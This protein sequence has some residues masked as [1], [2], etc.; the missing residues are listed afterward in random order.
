[1]NQ[2]GMVRLLVVLPATLERASKF[3]VYAEPRVVRLMHWAS[4]RP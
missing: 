1:M 3:C 2:P 4:A